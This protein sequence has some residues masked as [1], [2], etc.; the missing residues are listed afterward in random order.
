VQQNVN[1][2][3]QNV[4]PM[5]QNVNR[6]QQ[7]V[8]PK[9]LEDGSYIYSCGKCNKTYEKKW[10]AERHN[11]TCKGQNDIHKCLYCNLVLSCSSAKSRHYRICKN[12][13]EIESKALI[14][15]DD[16]HSTRDA[17]IVP[18]NAA[19]VLTNIT[20]NNAETINNIT[21]T[22]TTTS[23]GDN[24]N[25][26]VTVNNIIVYD[27]K[28]MEL[29]SDHITKNQLKKMVNDFDVTKVLTDYSTALLSRS[30][31]QCVRK[32]NLRSTSSAIHMGDD[33]WEYHSDQVVLP[34]LLSNIATNLG[35]IQND[36]KIKI[37]EQLDTFIIDVQ[38][39]AIDCH[40]DPKEDARL[41]V[42]FKRTL[43]NVKHLLF[44]LTKQTIAKKR[45]EL[46][47]NVI[48]NDISTKI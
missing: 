45:K 26:N 47:E 32:T 9:I 34:K 41:K 7:N 5:Q 36:Y 10:I 48:H 22:N 8:N 21:N 38:S 17:S 39:E 40:E 44:N 24:S 25:N 28:N 19:N 31:N 29:L 18:A 15:F 13:L 12:K 20:N 14:V 42:L 30:E 43:G 1:P 11:K 35:N 16:T 27:P 6:V 23:I 2:V 33:K 46:E 4:N 3:Q 37:M